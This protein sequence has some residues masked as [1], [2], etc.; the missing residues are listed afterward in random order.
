MADVQQQAMVYYQLMQQGVPPAEAFKQAF[1]EG[2]PNSAANR[3]KAQKKQA[4]NQQKA[5]LAQTGGVL[6]GAL[7]TRAAYDAATG[8]PILGGVFEGSKTAGTAGAQAGAQA[9]TK[10]GATAATT[11]TSQAASQAGTAAAA[12]A[13]E[14]GAVTSVAAGEAV[15]AGY[16]AVG[17]AADG[18]TIVASNS[19]LSSG[20]S[21]GI[22]AGDMGT[23]LAYAYGAYQGHKLLQSN[24]T[25]KEK[26]QGVHD[27]V[28]LGAADTFT[29]GLATPAFEFANS[30]WGGTMQK[31]RDFRSKIDPMEGVIAKWIGDKQFLTEGNRLRELHKK[32]IEVP[33]DPNGPLTLKHG[34]SKDKL[35]Q[36]A[37][38]TGGNVKFAESRNEADLTPQ[39]LLG[40]ATFY[41]KF[42][43]DWNSM[44]EEQKKA[45]AALAI[46]GGAVREHHGTVDV[47]WTKPGLEEGVSQFMGS[48]YKPAQG[49]PL[50]QAL[51]KPIQKPIGQAGAQ[52]QQLMG[53]MGTDPNM[54]IQKPIGQAPTQSP[55]WMSPTQ[56]NIDPGFNMNAAQPQNMGPG[57]RLPMP[58]NPT[59]AGYGQA[60]GPRQMS[61]QDQ[62]RMQQMMQQAQQQ[63]RRLTPQEQWR[64]NQ[65]RGYQ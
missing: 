55:Q 16:T 58:Q 31:G 22:T 1:P 57:N 32:G 59:Q 7:A 54:Q 11:G 60:P 3:E 17:T 25:G 44:D 27:R 38:D 52:G 42:G 43:N 34:R 21:E 5:A 9:T 62:Q 20:A 47:D 56:G 64:V 6:A 41:E 39:D 45:I 13:V 51:A 10:A 19:A 49:S 14:S 4:G 24:A 40:Y 28:E 35:I 26:A 50:A 8:Q 33:Q 18:G 48:N 12:Q 53:A 2:L 15:P 65:I 63:G 61:P 29:F 37:K 46:Q 23:Y 36:I 30:R